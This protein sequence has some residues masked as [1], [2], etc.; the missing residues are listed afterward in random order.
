MSPLEQ[1]EFMY[2]IWFDIFERDQTNQ[3]ALDASNIYYDAI[4]LLK[5]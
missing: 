3:I 1:M 4:I 5:Q 2:M